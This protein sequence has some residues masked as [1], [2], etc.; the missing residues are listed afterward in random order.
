MKTTCFQL[1]LN[2][3]STSVLTEFI[4]RLQ[5]LRKHHPRQPPA[6]MQLCSLLLLFNVFFHPSLSSVQPGGPGSLTPHPFGTAHACII[7]RCTLGSGLL[8]T[9]MLLFS[10]NPV[11]LRERVMLLFLSACPL[12]GEP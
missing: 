1:H 12:L 2:Q 11:Q 5:L 3:S 4:H 10:F 9:E 6:L 8:F 7:T